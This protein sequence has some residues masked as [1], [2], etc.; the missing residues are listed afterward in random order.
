M[1]VVTGLLPLL[2]MFLKSVTADGH[3][4]LAAYKDVLASGNQWVLLRHSIVLSFLTALITTAAGMLLGIELLDHIIFSH[5]GY[6]SF[7]EEG[8]M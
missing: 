5:K 8:E 3:L 6:F 7:L 2:I 1:L 4:S